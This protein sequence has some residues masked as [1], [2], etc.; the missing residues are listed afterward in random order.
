M[1]RKK[2]K[3]KKANNC[4]ILSGRSAQLQLILQ[5]SQTS[6]TTSP[7]LRQTVEPVASDLDGFIDAPEIMER[8]SRSA[9]SLIAMPLRYF[10]P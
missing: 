6:M 8:M 10:S 1:Q 7:P 4:R 3:K 9:L 5:R 2:K